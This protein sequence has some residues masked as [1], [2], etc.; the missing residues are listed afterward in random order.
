MDEGRLEEGA[1]LLRNALAAS[2]LRED[3]DD[4]YMEL[5]VLVQLIDALFWTHAFDEVEPLIL[6]FRKAAEA[7]SLQDGRVS[8][9]Y[10]ELESLY[11][12]ARLHEVGN[13]STPRLLSSRHGR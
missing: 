13:P 3:E 4:T 10:W 12:S 8:F 1:D 7:K 9:C 6:R 2:S 5:E 11:A